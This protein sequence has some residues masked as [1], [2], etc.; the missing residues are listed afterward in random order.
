MLSTTVSQAQN[1]K[2]YQSGY[3]V[4]YG[5]GSEGSRQ[6]TRLAGPENARLATPW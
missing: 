3:F 4:P 1:R 5:P 2:S 6:V